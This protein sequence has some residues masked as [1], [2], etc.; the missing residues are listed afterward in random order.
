M[1]MEAGRQ[2]HRVREREREREWE[3]ESNSQIDS[4]L[5]D[6]WKSWANNPYQLSQFCGFFPQVGLPRTLVRR[7]ETCHHL[8]CNY[9]KKKVLAK[10]CWI[11]K[12]KNTHTHKVGARKRSVV[13]SNILPEL[14][15]LY[16]TI[17]RNYNK[18]IIINVS[19]RFERQT[20]INQLPPSN[21][22]PEL[23]PLLKTIWLSYN[24]YIIINVSPRFERQ[25]TINQ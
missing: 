24:K 16:K 19:L 15:L 17:W 6:T 21:I 9:R 23:R 11:N 4:R 14:R 20:A 13:H 8:S 25:T 7:A 5:E 2:R 22:L 12:K 10:H 1:G 3:R 18:Y